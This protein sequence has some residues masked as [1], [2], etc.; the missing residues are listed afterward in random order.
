MRSCVRRIYMLGRPTMAVLSIAFSAS[1]LGCNP[2]R[3][4]S[5]GSA[6]ADAS[7]SSS[8]V[9][10]IGPPSGAAASASAPAPAPLPPLPA[11]P[12]KG[13]KP[14]TV[15]EWKDQGT[16]VRIPH[17]DELGCAVVMLREWISVLCTKSRYSA[18]PKNVTVTRQVG[19]PGAV[20]TS[21][22]GDRQNVVFPI[23][24]GIDIE[25]AFEWAQPS[26]GKKKLTAT[27]AEG[28]PNPAVAF[29]SGAPAIAAIPA[30]LAGEKK[31]VARMLYVPKGA[32][33]GGVVLDGLWLDETETTFWAYRGCV[34]EGGCKPPFGRGI[35]CANGFDDFD[36][37][38]PINCVTWDEANNYCAWANK[39]L[40]TADEWLYGFSGSDGRI[41]PWGNQ[42]DISRVC[43]YM[44]LKIDRIS[45]SKANSFYGGCLV[46]S[47][48]EGKGPF[49]HQDMLSN[50]Q[51][52]TSTEDHGKR[53]V[54]G[55]A[56]G[57]VSG[58]LDW[59]EYW[60]GMMRSLR[61]TYEPGAQA[62]ETGFRCARSAPPGSTPPQDLGTHLQMDVRE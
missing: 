56:F 45:P 21:S 62:V 48:P 38:Q 37:M 32:R 15:Q 36:P 23:R 35:G 55:S 59:H 44:V 46:G 9:A 33:K 13:S 47:H 6:P 3:R 34:E 27:Y 40:P 26:W 49:G 17:S 8:A 39:R 18:D 7:G 10:P 22:R 43:D 57:S 31:N 28:D 61:Q 58:V 20:L 4:G 5:S 25:V 2:D 51:E 50:V 54:L 12:S 30:A 14:P 1:A 52:W 29:D 53:V 42:A 41:Y 19:A 60:T 24:A 16:K 11:P